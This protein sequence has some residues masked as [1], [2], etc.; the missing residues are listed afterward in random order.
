[1]CPFARELEFKLEVFGENSCSRWHQDKYAGRAIVSY[2]GHVGNIRQVCGKT[3]GRSVREAI[4]SVTPPVEIAIYR[5]DVLSVNPTG[6]IPCAAPPSEATVS[7][8]QLSYKS[9]NEQ[10]AALHSTAQRAVSTRRPVDLNSRYASTSQLSYA[11]PPPRSYATPGWS[12]RPTSNIGQP[13]TYRHAKSLAIH[14]QT[15]PRSLSSTGA[16]MDR[17]QGQGTITKHTDVE[18]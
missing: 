17:W 14:Q 18:L 16:S 6:G 10:A 9:P 1:M 3:Y 8:Q 7:T 15:L 4:N 2:T 11:P 12:E 13:D 5:S